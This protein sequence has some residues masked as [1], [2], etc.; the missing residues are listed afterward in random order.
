MK[1]V[2]TIFQMATNAPKAA[3]RVVKAVATGQPVLVSPEIAA[4][5]SQICASCPDNDK[6]RCKLCGCSTCGVILNK[7]KL[8]TEKC[9]AGRWPMKFNSSSN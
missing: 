7:T 2:R 1:T 3:A 8:T 5:R 4:T 6:G 9:P